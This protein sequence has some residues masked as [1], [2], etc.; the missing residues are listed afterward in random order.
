[1]TKMVFV[2][3]ILRLALLAQDDKRGCGLSSVGCAALM[4]APAR[5]VARDGDK[6]SIAPITLEKGKITLLPFSP[7]SGELH[8]ERVKPPRVY[9]P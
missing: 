5:Y 6:F 2:S 4:S 9:K 7:Y 1:M 8:A 3:E